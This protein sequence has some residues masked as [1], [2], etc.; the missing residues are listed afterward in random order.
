MGFLS[1]FLAAANLVV[2]LGCSSSPIALNDFESGAEK[3]KPDPM[4]AERIRLQALKIKSKYASDTKI[5]YVSL[6]SS[7]EFSEYKR[8]VAGLKY[9]P[10]ST[11]K[12]KQ[13]KLA[14][15]INIYNALTVHGIVDQK[16]QNSVRDQSSFFAK[17]AYNIDGNVYSLNDIENGI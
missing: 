3:M 12:T 2:L 15:W 7:T 17:V 10:L 13:E 5:D 9:F 16:I 6:A 4:I 1:R 14:F 8:W 11:L